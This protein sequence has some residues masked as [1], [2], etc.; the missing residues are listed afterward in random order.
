M[1]P[2]TLLLVPTV[3]LSRC[4]YLC[5]CFV[6]VICSHPS[7]PSL[8]SHLNSIQ[9][10]HEF[11]EFVAEDVGTV[12]SGLNSVVLANNN[13]LILMPLN[14]PTYGTRRK[15]QIQTYLE[16][17]NVCVNAVLIS[18]VLYCMLFHHVRNCTHKSFSIFHPC[19]NNER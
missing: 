4:T 18:S 16:Q 3:S 2:P 8:P 10:F 19:M 6:F 12:D 14:E 15:S 5:S 9:G 17:N 7:S 13:E 11:A 1:P